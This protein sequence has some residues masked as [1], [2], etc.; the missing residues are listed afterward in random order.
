MDAD[1]KVWEKW[2][3]ILTRR[4]FGNTVLDLLEFIGPIGIF[5][6]QFLYA[7]QP[8]INLLYP[9]NNS[10]I[11]A[12]LLEDNQRLDLFKELLRQENIK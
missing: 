5:G 3:K 1:Q 7:F 9:G 11:L 2:A 4:G 6:A 10:T 8:I 12:H